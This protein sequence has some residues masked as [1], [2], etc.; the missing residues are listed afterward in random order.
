GAQA[1]ADLLDQLRAGLLV[2]RLPQELD[3]G[4]VLVM[5]GA[6]LGQLEA[7]VPGQWQGG[8]RGQEGERL[9]TGLLLR[10]L[11]GELRQRHLRG[12]GPSLFGS[13]ST[14]RARAAAISGSARARWAQAISY[15]MR[16]RTS[17]AGCFCFSCSAWLSRNAMLS[18]SAFSPSARSAFAA[19]PWALRAA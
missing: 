9:G 11:Q 2:Q 16:A 17:A 6:Q 13:S 12:A 4:V 15:S 19:I 7:R 10:R 5:L 18:R 3:G 8:E 1:Q 14:T